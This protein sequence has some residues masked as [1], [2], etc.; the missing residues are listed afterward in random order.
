MRSETKSCRSLGEGRKKTAILI[1]MFFVFCF[2]SCATVTFLTPVYPDG[3]SR[4]KLT[5]SPGRQYVDTEYAMQE[6]NAYNHTARD[7]S[8]DVICVWSGIMGN[9]LARDKESIVLKSGTRKL[10]TLAALYVTDGSLHVYINC[11]MDNVKLVK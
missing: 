3:D 11:S 2:A 1:A 6:I 4:A 5:I 8:M 10:L 9:E 7:Y